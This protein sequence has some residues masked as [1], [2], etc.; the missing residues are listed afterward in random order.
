MTIEHGQGQGGG[1]QQKAGGTAK[2]P[3]AKAVRGECGPATAEAV[4]TWAKEELALVAAL[5]VRGSFRDGAAATTVVLADGDSSD[6]IVVAEANSAVLLQQVKAE[7]EAAC[8]EPLPRDAWSP[9]PPA[10]EKRRR[11]SRPKRESSG[12]AAAPGAPGEKA[13]GHARRQTT[14]STKVTVV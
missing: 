7:A 6:A 4:P 13:P 9:T 12:M 10:K 8:G 1:A 14:A 3:A 11:P 5:P 2:A